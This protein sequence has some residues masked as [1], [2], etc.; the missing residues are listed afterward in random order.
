MAMAGR[1]VAMGQKKAPVI[2]PNGGQMKEYLAWVCSEC[3]KECIR[4]R[5]ESRYACFQLSDQPMGKSLIA[6]WLRFMI[7]VCVDIV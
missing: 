1:M 2:G 5:E 4:I 3:N 7:G 6:C